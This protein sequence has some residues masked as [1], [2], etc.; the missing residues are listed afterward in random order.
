MEL[1]T[2][3]AGRSTKRFPFDI[4]DEGGKLILDLRP[5]VRAVAEER[6]KGKDPATIAATFHRTVIDAIA[7][8]AVAVREQTGLD[9]AVLSGGC[10]Q[11]RMLLEGTVQ[12]LEKGGFTVYT[13][14]LLP[15]NDGCIA[16]GQA[17]VA[18]AQLQAR[19]TRIED[20][21]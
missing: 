12:A 1:E 14:R 9:K 18:A 7:A 4:A 15:T 6:I 17:I 20:Q 3:A 13:H 11:N 8:M 2:I 19:G 21:G 16:L 10:F 5:L